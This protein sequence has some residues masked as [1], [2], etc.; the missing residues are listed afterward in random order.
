M[1]TQQDIYASDSENRPP[2]LSKENYIQW[3]SRMIHYAKSIENGKMLAKSILEEE[4]TADE[5]K[6][7]VYDDQVIQLLLL[8]LTKVGIQEK[9]ALLLNELDQFTFI[10]D[11]A[12]KVRAKRFAKTRDPLVLFAN[13]SYPSPVYTPEQL[14]PTNTNYVQPPPVMENIV[15]VTYLV[16]AINMAYALMSKAFKMHTLSE[17]PQYENYYENDMFNMFAHEKQHPKLP[18]SIQGTYMKQ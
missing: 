6:Q 12:T 8:G 14:S 17:V 18:E 10:D 7:V 13:T 11:E 16:A 9:E 4:L 1:D 5:A 3:P 15:D 2:M